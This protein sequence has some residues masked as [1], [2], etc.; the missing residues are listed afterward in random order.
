MRFPDL[1]AALR[2]VTVE[3]ATVIGLIEPIRRHKA[4]GAVRALDVM[5]GKLIWEFRFHSPPWAGLA[6]GLVAGDGTTSSG[7]LTN[8]DVITGDLTV[9][10][11][12]FTQTGE[13]TGN[14]TVN[15][16]STV[17]LQ[18]T[19]NSGMSFPDVV[20]GNFT[21]YTG[22]RVNFQSNETDV[23]GT[24]TSTDLNSNNTGP[25]YG[26]YLDFNTGLLLVDG[27]VSITGGTIR[28]FFVGGGTTS[29]AMTGNNGNI[30]GTIGRFVGTTLIPGPELVFGDPADQP[31]T[32]WSS[33]VFQVTNNP[34]PP[35]P[36]PYTHGGG[37]FAT[38]PTGISQE[39]EYNEAGTGPLPFAEGL[40]IYAGSNPNQTN[41]PTH[42][43]ASTTGTI[44]SGIALTLTNPAMSQTAAAAADGSRY[45]F[46][47]PSNSGPARMSQLMG[48]APWEI[49]QNVNHG[50]TASLRGARR[51]L[52]DT[53]NPSLMRCSWLTPE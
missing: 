46:T 33:F 34:S 5:T 7:Q 27:N 44:K 14:V 20:D 53:P 2:A 40:Y 16:L 49:G 32:P 39:N 47:V 17:N 6:G 42:P 24:F 51:T 25:A 31:P 21:C 15:N 48:G 19:V 23:N 8:Y 9:T 37:L 52:H 45:S 36:M 13:V 28:V 4:Y 22:S 41:S 30:S 3:P 12:T 50:T 1:G 10:G 11:G 38:L 43:R 26:S 29:F 35:A 18:G